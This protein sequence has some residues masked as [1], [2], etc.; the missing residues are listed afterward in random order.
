MI[1]FKH[2]EY[3]KQ[4]TNWVIHEPIVDIAFV[5]ETIPATQ[6]EMETKILKKELRTEEMRGVEDE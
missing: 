5:E 2:S 4:T 1:V 6:F 3:P